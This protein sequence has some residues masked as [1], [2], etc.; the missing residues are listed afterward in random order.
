MEYALSHSPGRP[1]AASARSKLYRAA[2]RLLRPFALALSLG[3]FQYYTPPAAAGKRLLP[4]AHRR[5]LSDWLGL[6]PR[7]AAVPLC[8]RRALALQLALLHA[9]GLLDLGAPVLRPTFAAG[10][11]LRLPAVEQSGALAAAAGERL[12]AAAQALGLTDAVTIDVAAW[13]AQF[14]SRLSEEIASGDPQ[15]AT[16]DTAA[17]CWRL[18]LPADTPPAL[19]FDLLQLGQWQ[20]LQR[21]G[22]LLALTPRS[23]AR[24]AQRG[25]GP[26]PTAHLLETVLRHPLAPDRRRLLHD[27]AARGRAYRLRA[28]CLLE[29]AQA[30]Q[31]SAVLAHRR[32]RPHV[33]RLLSPRHAVVRAE[34]APMLDRWLSRQGYE[35]SDELRVT[36]DEFRG[37]GSSLV[38]HHSSLAHVWFALRV[39]LGLGEL[40][41]LPL[42]PPHDQLAA[43]AA[44]LAPE[45]LG[46]LEETAARFLAEWRAALRGRD[47]FLPA[48]HPA[49]PALLDAVGEA[50]T[51]GRDLTL[52]YQALGEVAPRLRRVRPL[53]LERRGDLYYLHAD[54]DLAQAERTFRLDRV[55]NE[56]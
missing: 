4:A 27:W 50:L 48:G 31:L 7:P 13:A 45:E 21:D 36:S 52:Y 25:Y 28:V 40:V 5:R 49:D 19:L 32:F 56:E 3:Y 9:A 18:R 39:L 11:W 33:L 38:T 2:P 6:S 43:A 54:C 15:P 17:D 1:T 8:R 22:G 55:M 44:G 35:L 10:R 16:L 26:D 47:A 20:P 24:A 29:T 12:S 14:L 34:M 53:R 23:I 42:P 51:H 41:P 46:E 30:E 37:D